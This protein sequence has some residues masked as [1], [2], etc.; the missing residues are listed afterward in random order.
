MEKPSKPDPGRH[1]AGR[2][3]RREVSP[4]QLQPSETPGI[5]KS[6]RAAVDPVQHQRQRENDQNQ[7]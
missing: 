2:V 3:R 4:V 6:D 1:Y 5:S 7:R